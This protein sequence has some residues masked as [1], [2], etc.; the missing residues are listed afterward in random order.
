MKATEG[1]K[2]IAEFMD[3]PSKG[4]SSVIAHSTL[5]YH[6]SWD[7]LMPVVRKIVELCCDQD[8]DYLFE[9]DHYTSILD[10]VPVAIIEDVH[11]VVVEFIQWYNEQSK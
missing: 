3:H 10:T 6:T 1:N 4:L 5:K 11:K 9:S 2:L 7:W 8:N